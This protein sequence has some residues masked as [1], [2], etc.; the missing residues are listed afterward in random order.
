MDYSRCL[1]KELASDCSRMWFWGPARSAYDRRHP[2]CWRL[3]S[4]SPRAAR[5]GPVAAYDAEQHSQGERIAAE[6]AKRSSLPS[7]C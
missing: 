2:M 6:E 7:V 3:I 5:A 1:I 4:R